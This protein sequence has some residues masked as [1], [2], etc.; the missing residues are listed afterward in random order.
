MSP[1]LS[2]LMGGRARV[3]ARVMNGMNKI[4]T[5]SV[6]L[7]HQDGIP[8]DGCNLPTTRANIFFLY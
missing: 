3:N 7:P 1:D 5:L 4:Q 8:R 6:L 2:L